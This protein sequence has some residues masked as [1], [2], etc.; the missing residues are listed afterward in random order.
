VAGSQLPKTYNVELP[1]CNPGSQEG[2]YAMQP[3]LLPHEI[4]GGLELGSKLALCQAGLEAMSGPEREKFCSYCT[5]HALDPSRCLALGIHGDGVPFSTSDSIT[6]F[7]ICV[8]G[9]TGAEKALLTGVPKSSHC[10]CGCRGDPSRPIPTVFPLWEGGCGRCS[11]PLPRE[12]GCWGWGGG[13]SVA[14]ERRGRG[15]RFGE[16][17]GGGAHLLVG[18]LTP[19][20]G[21]CTTT[22]LMECIK[23]SLL[24]LFQGVYPSCDHRGVAFQDKERRKLAGR[25]LGVTGL[26]V[27]CRGDWQ[28]FRSV[29]GVSSWAADK[30]CWMCHASRSTEVFSESAWN[31]TEDGP[32][33]RRRVAEHEFYARLEQEG[34]SPNPLFSLPYFQPRH[35]KIDVLHCADLG[36]TPLACGH[37]L[38]E[39]LKLVHNGPYADAVKVLFARLRDFYKEFQPSTRLGNLT[40]EM[41]RQRG[42]C[43]KLRCKGAE[44]RHVLPFCLILCAENRDDGDLHS[45]TRHA[46]IRELFEFYCCLSVQPFQ[47][48][49][50]KQHGL[51]FLQHWRALHLEAAAEGRPLLYPFKPK[52]HIFAE[53]LHH[54]LGAYGD[55]SRYWCYGDEDEMGFLL[56]S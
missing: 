50:C 38:W 12:P 6:C 21:A 3:V 4:F 8:A 2:V 18:R 42:S 7:T 14:R 40:L 39:C 13:A 15:R 19:L 5:E 1:L 44:C 10:P 47:Q 34:S 29:F 22:A 43:P 46:M 28:F 23:W 56:V 35:I 25:S 49:K 36:V 24:Q 41:I 11:P 9:V 55:P 30:V 53:L 51:A 37:V 26:L 17:G 31:F 16:G 33:V 27:E 48:D 52:H 20:S 45:R 54:Q 32:I